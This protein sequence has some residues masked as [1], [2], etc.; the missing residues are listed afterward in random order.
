VEG[1]VPGHGV[2]V[3]VDEGGDAGFVAG[4]TF[5][6]PA[7]LRPSRPYINPS[8]STARRVPLRL[9]QISTVA[10]VRARR[11]PAGLRQG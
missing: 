10:P 2:D 11:S 1:L 4:E 5:T 3:F 8:Q 6:R 7:N 9:S